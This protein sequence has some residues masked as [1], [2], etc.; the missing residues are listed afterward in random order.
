MNYQWLWPEVYVATVVLTRPMVRLAMKVLPM[1]TVAVLGSYTG[2]VP[3]LVRATVVQDL[4]RTSKQR[5]LY[6]M[7]SW[8]EING[9]NAPV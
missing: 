7:T 3:P 4:S 9:A 8:P 6:H 5:T 2:V 1:L